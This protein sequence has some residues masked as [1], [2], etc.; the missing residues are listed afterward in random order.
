MWFAARLQSMGVSQ[1][2]LSAKSGIT[3]ADLSR[4]QNRKQYPKANNLK[5]LSEA[6]EVTEL[7]LMI[8]LGVL[9]IEP[10]KSRKFLTGSKVIF[11]EQR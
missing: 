9:D 3:Q 8:G 2:D 1:R 6:L 10:P 4:Y 5:A 11:P 7:E